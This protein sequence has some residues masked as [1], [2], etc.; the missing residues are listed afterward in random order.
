[1]RPRQLGRAGALTILLS[2][3]VGLTGCVAVP[4]V[5]GPDRA[6][7]QKI[8][9]PPPDLDPRLLEE[10]PAAL[11]A[12]SPEMKRFLHSVV[13]PEGRLEEKF[14]AIYSNLRYNAA[15]AIQYDALATLTADEAFRQ[16]RGNCLSFAAMFIALAREAGLDARF[17]EVKVPPSWDAAGRDTLVQYRHVNVL[18]QITPRLS[19]VVDLRMDLYSESDPRRPLSDREAL[20]HYYSNISME[21]LFDKR[22]GEAWLAARRAIEADD[23]QSFIWNNMGIV[24]RRLGNSQLA[25]ASF[26]QALALNPRDWSALSNLSH[27]YA[28]RGEKQEAERLR[29]LGDQ[30]RLRDP[31]YRY[32]LAE[33]AYRRGAYDEAL[34][35]L[36]AALGQ[37]RGDHRFYYLRGLSLWQLGQTDSAISNLRRAMDATEESKP[38]ALYQRQ[39][40]TWQDSRG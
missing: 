19:G 23:S 37:H 18:S 8:F 15:F 11:L 32:A 27:I 5:D 17:Q 29:A 10:A 9:V 4:E 2:A 1:M 34:Q 12:V 3:L 20:A 13:P 31:Y 6:Q 7:L 25:E 33:S 26:R 40:E 28:R 30:I 14:D 21:Y 35:Q 39:L 38:L 24:Q 22:L 36:D 16:R